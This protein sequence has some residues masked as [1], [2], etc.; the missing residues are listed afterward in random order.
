MLEH[1]TLAPGSSWIVRRSA[2]FASTRHHQVHTN[3][4]R[5]S[6]LQEHVDAS[7]EATLLP[8]AKSWDN[9][10]GIPERTTKYTIASGVCR[11]INEKKRE[12]RWKKS[13]AMV[14]LAS[15]NVTIRLR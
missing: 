13:S 12:I 3:V 14:Q 1:V 4:S 8:L 6:D 5:W 7:P 11:I 9:D 10:A 2:I 15:G